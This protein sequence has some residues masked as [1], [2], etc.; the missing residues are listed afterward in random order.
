M[1]A[2]FSFIKH[3]S[4]QSTAFLQHMWLT[5]ETHFIQIKD[6][7]ENVF[8]RTRLNVALPRHSQGVLFKQNRDLK[9]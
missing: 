6:D 2:V 9:S 8:W 3:V 7:T 4:T 5:R 1:L